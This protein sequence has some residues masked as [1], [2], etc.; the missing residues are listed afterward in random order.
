MQVKIID[1]EK[2]VAYIENNN[3]KEF[4]IQKKLRRYVKENHTNAYHMQISTKQ[5]FF[6]QYLLNNYKINSIIHHYNA[7]S[8]LKYQN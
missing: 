7:P 6:F 8:E 4:D 5:A 2:I 1:I 3:F